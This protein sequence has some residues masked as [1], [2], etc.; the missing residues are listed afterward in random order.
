VNYYRNGALLHTSAAPAAY[1]LVAAASLLSPGGRIEDASLGGSLALLPEVPV[2]AAPASLATSLRPSYTWSA[3]G[4]ATVYELF[5]EDALGTPVARLEVAAG[6]ACAAG[7]CSATPPTDLAAGQRYVWRIR[8]RNDVGYGPWSPLTGFAAPSRPPVVT[9]EVAAACAAA[10]TATFTA[11]A[12]DP[13]GDA[14]SYSWFGCGTGAGTERTCTADR[15]GDLTAGVTATDGKGGDATATRSVAVYATAWTPGAWGAC[16]GE[17]SWTCTSGAADGC[18]R[19]GLETRPLTETAWSLEGTGTPPAREQ[20]C[21]ERAR[22]YVAAWS[23]SAW[24]A[25]SRSC[26]GGT[27]TRTVTAVGWK[28]EA[29][30]APKPAVSRACNTA[31][32]PLTC[33]DY[34]DTYPTR[35]ECLAHR[36]PVC[37]RRFRDDGRGNMLTCWKGFN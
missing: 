9:L 10:C 36:W 22:G 26:G 30:D 32:C 29:P 4:G 16:V 18:S 3:A 28:A 7:P 11:A 8:A 17:G 20:P 2:P 12:A 21:T 14:V 31:A 34:S 37:E 15:A 6:G 33:Y 23:T 24:S 1:P 13:D 25:C 19:P 27:Q 5:L 35:P